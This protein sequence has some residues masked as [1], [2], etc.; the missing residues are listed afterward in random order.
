MTVHQFCA[1]VAT[2][3]TLA[4]PGLAGAAETSTWARTTVLLE[5]GSSLEVAPEQMLIPGGLVF[6]D[7][8]DREDLTEFE[9]Q[10]V[11]R[12]GRIGAKIADVEQ[13]MRLDPL[14]VR[15]YSLLLPKNKVAPLPALDLNP[16]LGTNLKLT[17][18]TPE[19]A[20]LDVE[21]YYASGDW[22]TP[23]FTGQPITIS[24]QQADLRQVMANFSGVVGT[25]IVVDPD[26][27]GEVSVDFRNVPWDQAPD[28][29]LM[30]NDLGWVVEGDS[31]R[32]SRLETLNRRR[33]VLAKATVAVGRSPGGLAMVAGRDGP[34]TPTVVLVVEPLEE[35]P[36]TPSRHAGLLRFREFKMPK[37]AASEPADG[38]VVL[39]VTVTEQGAVEDPQVLS[40][41][42]ESASRAALEATAGWHLAPILDGNGRHRRAVVAFGVR[43]SISM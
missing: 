3:A 24:L 35:A 2:A 5:P 36:P 4:A 9:A 33:D 21:F 28:L 25:P 18:L 37:F 17:D 34:E 23:E 32:V 41:P 22:E 27:E 8:L 6:T 29:I 26:V 30:T 40:S 39:C 15:Q 20:T 12:V 7:E 10:A 1:V 43:T 13:A 42:S 19:M 38:I 16:R 11:L 14:M 31:I